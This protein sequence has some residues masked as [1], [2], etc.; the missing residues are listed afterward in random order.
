MCQYVVRC[1]GYN[2]KGDILLP[3]ISLHRSREGRL[4]NQIHPRL[5]KYTQ[6]RN[7]VLFPEPRGEL[8]AGKSPEWFLSWDLRDAWEWG[9]AAGR[10]AQGRALLGGRSV[11]CLGSRTV[12]VAQQRAEGKLCPRGWREQTRSLWPWGSWSVF[13]NGKLQKAFKQGG[14]IR[15]LFWKDRLDI[16]TENQVEGDWEAMWTLLRVTGLLQSWWKMQTLCFPE[17]KTSPDNQL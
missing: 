7:R 10:V 5:Y 1:W 6:I 16:C 3:A 14:N 17:K 2:D 13:H 8:G 12:S 4:Y 11:V 9:T 15:F